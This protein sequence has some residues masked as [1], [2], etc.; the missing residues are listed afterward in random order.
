MTIYGSVIFV[1]LVSSCKEEAEVGKRVG[2]RGRSQLQYDIVSRSAIANST[3]PHSHADTLLFFFLQN[4]RDVERSKMLEK[5]AGVDG[6]ADGEDSSSSAPPVTSNLSLKQGEKIK[7]SIGGGKVTK[8]RKTQPTDSSFANSIVRSASQALY[9]KHRTEVNWL[10]ELNI[11]GVLF[12]FRRVRP[13]SNCVCFFAR[14]QSET[15]RLLKQRRARAQEGTEFQ[16][17]T[18]FVYVTS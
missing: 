12:L 5:R 8:P 10:L 11:F 2:T 16:A 15:S 4:G 1:F 17:P 3:C 18:L 13:G 14:Q 7:I 6:N 9:Q